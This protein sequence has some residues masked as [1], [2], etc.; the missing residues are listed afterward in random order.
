[1]CGIVGYTGGSQALPILLEGLGRLEYRGYD[2]AGVSVS[3][4]DGIITVKAEGRLD[5]LRARL[6]TPLQGCCGLGHTRWATHG[7]PTDANAHPHHNNRVYMIH[8]GI[9]ENYLELKEFLSGHGY[10][11]VSETD[12]EVAAALIDFHYHGDPFEAIRDSLAEIEGA[13]AFGL[14][15]ADR[16]VKF[17]PSAKRDR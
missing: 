2:S 16:P 14:M 10:G 5:N 1:M 13:F 4:P 3:G 11:F 17:M 15:F 7:A 12:T 9:I 6:K 8:N